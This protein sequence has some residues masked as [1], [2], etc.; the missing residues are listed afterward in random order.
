MTTTL[1]R[2]KDS[3]GQTCDISISFSRNV[4]G[5][6]TGTWRTLEQGKL[7]VTG[8]KLSMKISDQFFT[9]T[10]G[11]W[12]VLLKNSEGNWGIKLNGVL[13]H[14]LFVYLICDGNSGEGF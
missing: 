3:A 12:D 5:E 4:F 2:L 7:S 8:G 14:D 9:P 10:F 1:L 11:L 6:N 13:F